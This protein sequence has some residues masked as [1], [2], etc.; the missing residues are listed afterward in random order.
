MPHAFIIKNK[1]NFKILPNIISNIEHLIIKIDNFIIIGAYNA[2]RN[3]IIYRELLSLEN[4]VI[5]LGDL[6]SKHSDWDSNCTVNNT[7]GITLQKF[8]EDYELVIHYSEEPTFFPFSGQTPSTLVIAITKNIPNITTIRTIPTL[9]SDHDPVYI[10]IKTTNKTQ[11]RQGQYYD[12][13]TTNRK[14]F[15]R[16]LDSKIAIKI[17]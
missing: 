12:F 2:P 4:R 15:R 8:A 7:N 3:R 11:T 16:V 14:E 9:N 6:N 17:T 10:E 13:S 5:L 1:L